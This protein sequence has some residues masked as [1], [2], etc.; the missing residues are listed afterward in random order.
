VIGSE[1]DTE[2][3]SRKGIHVIPSPDTNRDSSSSEESESKPKEADT[4][5][6]YDSL[7]GQ[8]WSDS[9]SRPSSRLRDMDLLSI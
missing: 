8:L 3:I 1:V 2:T 4:I 6:V 7:K 9:R 5:I